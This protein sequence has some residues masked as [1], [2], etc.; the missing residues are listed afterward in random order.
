MRQRAI[1]PRYA[2]HR[3]RRHR[4]RRRDPRGKTVQDHQNPNVTRHVKAN[5][6]P[7]PP[8]PKPVP[9]GPNSIMGRSSSRDNTDGGMNPLGG[10]VGGQAAV[11]KMEMERGGKAKGAGY[12]SRDQ[13]GGGGGG[14][15]GSGA[16][17]GGGGGSGGG[18]SGGGVNDKISAALRQEV[19]RLQG[20]N[21]SLNTKCAML[22][23]SGGGGGSSGGSSGGGG[24][25]IVSP[26]QRAKGKAQ[27]RLLQAL[28]MLEENRSMCSTSAQATRH[29]LE[30]W[31]MHS[32]KIR[33]AQH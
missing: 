31:W 18:G 8:P 10:G 17:G 23:K 13:G 20:E 2:L 11:M 21:T 5:G 6:A 12:G 9:V 14:S 27:D 1:W 30:G 16:G 28:S 7:P 29:S 3:R 24:G 26:E 32:V 25:R 19:A 15:K 4:R 33:A 22:E